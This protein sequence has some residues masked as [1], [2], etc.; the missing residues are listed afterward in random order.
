MREAMSIIDDDIED[1]DNDDDSADDDGDRGASG[2]S[3]D[4]G[5]IKQ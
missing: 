3:D 2:S 1:A 5:H 4:C